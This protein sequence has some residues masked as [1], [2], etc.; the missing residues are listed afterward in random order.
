MFKIGKKKK[1][2]IQG[3]KWQKIKYITLTYH[4]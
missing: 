1:T 3:L 2:L 4:D